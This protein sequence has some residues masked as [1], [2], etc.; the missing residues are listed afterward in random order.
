MQN[1]CCFLNSGCGLCISLDGARL[2]AYMF[3]SICV[4]ILKSIISNGYTIY[5]YIYIQVCLYDIWLPA[6]PLQRKRLT[7]CITPQRSG[8]SVTYNP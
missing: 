7:L 8:L 4:D 2:Y 3:I 5:I 1:A 6:G